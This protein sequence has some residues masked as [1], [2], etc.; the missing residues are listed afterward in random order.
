MKNEKLKRITSSPTVK[1]AVV[2]LL[3][4]IAA[5]T[6]RRSAGILA[7]T[8][9]S[10]VCCFIAAFIGVGTIMK[11][12]VFGTTVF[13]VNTLE[14]DDIDVTLVF[15]TL[16]LLSI[17]FFSIS[18]AI[19]KKGKK[20]GYA[21]LC[22]GIVLCFALNIHYV[23]N[24]IKAYK[25]HNTITDYTESKYIASE[26]AYLG[27]FEYSSIYYR[28]DTKAFYVDAKSD[29]FPTVVGSLTSNGTSL[30]DGFLPLMEEKLAEPYL[31][32]MKALFRENYAD[33]T[34]YVN[35]DGF[36]LKPNENPLSSEKGELYG[37]LKYEIILGG[38]QTEKQMRERIRDY[39]N[40]LDD[41]GFDYAHLT[42]K[43]GIGIWERRYVVIDP[44]HM[45]G[46]FE[47]KIKYVNPYTSNE[48]NRYLDRI[49]YN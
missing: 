33:D 42:F 5:V 38:V 30:A 43:C 13:I 22:V 14:N 35:F 47:I 7:M 19:I 29:K 36:A 3:A 6:F 9:I 4:F 41:S 8:P 49:L 45:D 27:N 2:V 18:A 1:L 34:F 20:Y 46:E 23:G 40:L 10:L 39:V 48:F 21:I 26:N 31:L 25:A 15:S 44:N 16:C 12:T 17:L 32:E 24:P 11:A 28:Y 37:N